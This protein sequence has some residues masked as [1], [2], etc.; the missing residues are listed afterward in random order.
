[1][2]IKPSQ[3]LK[4]YSQTLQENYDAGE[5]QSLSRLLLQEFLVIDRT[6]LMINDDFTISEE[7]LQLLD[8]AIS[9]LILNEPI[10]YIIGQAHFYGRDYQV[11][12][13]VLI[14]RPETEELVDLMI[15]NH[16]T[17]SFHILDIGTGTGCIPITLA[18]AL[19]NS[20]LSAMDIS[21]SALSMAKSNALLHKANVQFIQKDILN[22]DL[23]EMYDIIVSNPPYITVKEK[24]QMHQNVL[25]FEPEIALFVP[26]EDP[27][28]FYRRIA[29]L[30]K[31]NLR[32]GG[33]LYFEINE[34]FG[35]ETKEMLQGYDYRE[36]QLIKDLS[37]KD[38][39]VTAEK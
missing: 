24:K 10:Q 27:L 38:R 30:G 21:E 2:N 25:A 26:D 29:E 39:I 36:V 37:N 20:K 35:R 12:P 19:F 15:K 18:K 11:S 7:Q 17:D 34:Y 14:P 9:R 28:L 31:S 23:S 3:L 8:Q 1:M 6:K 4:K 16:A 22:E 32:E 13:D 33:F 5:A